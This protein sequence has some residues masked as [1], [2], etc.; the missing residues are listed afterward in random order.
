[1]LY[2]AQVE[3]KIRWEKYNTEIKRSLTDYLK[4]K[5]KLC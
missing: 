3:V 4:K 5:K 1:M 2:S